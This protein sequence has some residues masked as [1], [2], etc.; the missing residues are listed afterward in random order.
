MTKKD[1]IGDNELCKGG[2]EDGE[3]EEGKVKTGK[4][5]KRMKIEIDKCLSR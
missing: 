3:E 2:L 4:R 1:W 5:T